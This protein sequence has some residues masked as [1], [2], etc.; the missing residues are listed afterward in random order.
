MHGLLFVSITLF[1]LADLTNAE[2]KQGLNSFLYTEALFKALDCSFVLSHLV[3]EE[4]LANVF[5]VFY[6]WFIDELEGFVIDI[7]CLGEVIIDIECI[8]RIRV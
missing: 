8:G 5:G 7:D 3:E 4:A 1:K 2:H 6:C